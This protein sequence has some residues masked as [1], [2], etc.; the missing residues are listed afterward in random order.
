MLLPPQLIIA[1][2][3][4]GMVYAIIGLGYA[5]VLNS[6]GILNFAQG[7][8]LMIGAL[9]IAV[10]YTALHLP[11]GMAVLAA[12]AAV[13]VVGYLS[14]YL[15]I[16]PLRRKQASVFS[17]TM[18]MVAA[19]IVLEQG[20]GVV[21]GKQE[22]PVD[23]PLPETP[24]ALGASVN[25]LPHTIY[26][27]TGSLAVFGLLYLFYHHT[28]FGKQMYAVGVDINAARAIGIDVQRAN[29]L[30]FTLGGL[31]A[32]AGGVLF[33]PLVGAHWLMGLPLT[34]KGFVAMVVGSPSRLEGP[35]IGGLVL[36]IAEVIAFRYI[37]T[38]YGSALAL[39]V[40]LVVLVV[41]P[42]G[43]LDK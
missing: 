24:I 8:F 20:A 34:L 42:A 28:N 39:V 32:A 6:T 27:V 12:L 33:A 26:L 38:A 7:D 40:L 36:G 4:S 11:Y 17:M 35:L 16:R 37:S 41:R 18:V 29:A 2:L 23:S 25:L 14:Q 5:T 1:G 22:L 43:L 19:M 31:V 13:G 10:A 9:T 30:A 3:Q 21:F 15:L